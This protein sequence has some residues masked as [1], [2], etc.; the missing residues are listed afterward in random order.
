LSK[1]AQFHN[2]VSYKGDI[3]LLRRGEI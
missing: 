3:L 1:S 2:Y